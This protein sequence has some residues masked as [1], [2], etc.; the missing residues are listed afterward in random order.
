MSIPGPYFR[1]KKSRESKEAIT[2]FLDE[3]IQGKTGG[4]VEVATVS[5]P[6]EIIDPE[7]PVTRFEGFWPIGLL[8]TLLPQDFV[9]PEDPFA[10]PIFNPSPQEDPLLLPMPLSH[11]TAKKYLARHSL[12]SF[13][14][15]SNEQ[16]L[17]Y[18]IIL[19]GQKFQAPNRSVLDTSALSSV[20]GCVSEL[21]QQ[22]M[23]YPGNDFP[24]TSL[25]TPPISRTSS[26]N[27][28]DWAS[29]YSPNFPI[30]TAVDSIPQ[31][32]IRPWTAFEDSYANSRW[33]DDLAWSRSD[34]GGYHALGSNMTHWPC[35]SLGNDELSSLPPPPF[36]ITYNPT[37]YNSGGNSSQEVAPLYLPIV[38]VDG[39][40]SLL[41]S[42]NHIIPSS[43]TC[44][45]LLS[46]IVPHPLVCSEHMSIQA[47]VRAIVGP[48]LYEK[49][50]VCHIL[51][52]LHLDGSM[53]RGNA[54]I[55]LKDGKEYPVPEIL[56][57]DSLLGWSQDSWKDKT[58][59]HTWAYHL[60]QEYQW[61]DIKYHTEDPIEA[62]MLPNWPG[63]AYYKMWSR[64]QAIWGHNG[65]LAQGQPIYDEDTVKAGKIRLKDLKV[66][67]KAMAKSEDFALMNFLVKVET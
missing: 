24:S 44:T 20:T 11:P 21:R 67:A 1:V 31:T 26:L 46:E 22:L 63:E 41:G 4:E 10:F 17:H 34:E 16:S 45:T 37:E 40:A 32:A 56:F 53:N 15:S 2:R 19:G 52:W 64:I 48:E 27:N 65:C 13:S 6:D 38:P 54:R 33:V 47:T 61:N 5:L 49:A 43:H 7:K 28:T 39:N 25:I 58:N 23:I 51:G 12:S 57:G 50:S 29:Q 3:V 36:H 30:T 35:P 9:P 42:S 55:R 59:I 8:N 60:V 14:D 66:M 18:I 62:I